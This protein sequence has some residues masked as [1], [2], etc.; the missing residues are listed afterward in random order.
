MWGAE[1][2]V[3]PLPDAVLASPQIR[4]QL[5]SMSQGPA[6][7]KYILRG[8]SATINGLIFLQSNLFLASGDGD[9]WLVIWSLASKRPIGV[10]KAHENGITGL[11][12][13][14]PDRILTHGRD[15]KLRVW[16]IDV[17]TPGLSL[18]LPVD[19]ATVDQPKPWLLHSLDISALNFCAFSICEDVH[20][21]DGD[22]Q[23]LLI[24]SANGLDSGGVDI[25]QLPSQHRISQLHSD[26]AV[27]TGM[28]M[29]V[30]IF[31]S[32]EHQSPRL[33]SG[34]EDGQV[35]VHQHVGAF[36]RTGSKWEKLAACKLHSQPVLSLEV[37]PERDYF[38][39]SS[40]D[41]QMAKFAIS[42]A[43]SPAKLVNTK[44]AGQQGLSIR[45][46][47]KIL[48]TAGWDGR[49][50]VYSCRTMKDL[51]VLKWH[52]EG[53]QSTAFADTLG[54]APPTQTG[55]EYR[56]DQLIT[57][58]AL[59]VIKQDRNLRAQSVHWLAVGAKD[60]KISLWDI[61]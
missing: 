38:F 31:Y 7:P 15:H 5:A 3:F 12:Y 22:E 43:S 36:G 39:T 13:W 1:A 29:A 56:S 26:K 45:S 24:A 4:F 42:D 51:A 20:T 6:T 47:G 52:K 40:A 30:E 10:F 50:R 2:P 19:G 18:R 59:D 25:F 46:D 49:V 28:L 14:S 48:A 41:A 35:M 33:V 32:S 34:Y 44:H 9:G 53:C 55:E 37:L 60:G 27:N 16:Q 17:E 54:Q 57:R 21:K 23:G 58:S 8:H 61:Y 11:K